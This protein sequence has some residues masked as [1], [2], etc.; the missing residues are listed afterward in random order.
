MNRGHAFIDS[1][2]DMAGMVIESGPHSWHFE[3]SD[4]FG[5]TAVS[6]KTGDPL[7]RQPG[8]RSG[9]WRAASIWARQGK[10]TEPNAGR[11]RAVWNE[12]PPA[13]YTMRGNLIVD[14][15]EPEGFDRDYSV[16]NY[17][18]ETGGA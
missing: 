6:A 18:Q 12:P 2:V 15:D 16:V 3:W 8:E 14:M 17:V 10:R 9:F 5:P 11:L 1:F 4:I 13:T 7:E